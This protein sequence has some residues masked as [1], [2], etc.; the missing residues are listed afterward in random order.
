MAKKRKKKGED[1]SVDDALESSKKTSTTL[2]GLLE[3]IKGGTSFFQ[4][5]KEEDEEFIPQLSYEKRKEIAEQYIM[6][7]LPLA[8]RPRVGKRTPLID[9]T[10]QITV[11]S[12]EESVLSDQ[13]QLQPP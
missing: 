9:P 4:R 3:R 1:T 11:Q 12:S 13:P 7:D 5:K 10:P 6:E 2:M 8:Q